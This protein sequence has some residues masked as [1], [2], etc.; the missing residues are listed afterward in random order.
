MSVSDKTRTALHN[1]GLTSY[2]IRSYLSLLERGAMTAR[3]VSNTALVPYSKIYEVLGSLEMKGWIESERGRPAKYYAKPPDEA[4][5]TTKLTRESLLKEGEVQILG[6]LTPIYERKEPQERP[7]IWIVRGQFSI[8]AKLREMLA[9]AKTEVLAALPTFPESMLDL[10]EGTLLHLKSQGV[11]IS[12]MTTPEIGK[13]VIRRIRDLAIVR[14]REQMFG[15][16]VVCDM[17]QVLLLL[18]EEGDSHGAL[19]I[20]ADHVG[21]TR[22]ARNYFEYLWQEAKEWDAPS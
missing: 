2:E 10:I 13:K 7:D 12:V 16:G 20:W 9:A 17:K 22:F 3:D 1:F 15:G 19:A 11:R 14:L 5:Q 18:E 6:E 8:L 21:L 4:I